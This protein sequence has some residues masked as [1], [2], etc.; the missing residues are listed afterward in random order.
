MNVE[1]GSLLVTESQYGT[2]NYYEVTA[3]YPTDHFS[4]KCYFGPYR[5]STS[6][7]KIEGEELH[8]VPFADWEKILLVVDV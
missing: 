1:V 4:V 8:L 3:T 6:F 5:G 7:A 2:P